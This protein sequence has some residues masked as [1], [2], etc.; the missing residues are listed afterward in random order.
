M[1]CRH[2]AGPQEIERIA[3]DNDILLVADEV[4][5]GI[6]RTGAMFAVEHTKVVPD[7]IA[8]AKGLGSGL[9]IG[10]IVFDA[11]LDFGVQGAH[12][13]TFGGNALA[14]ASTV[15]TLKTIERDGLHKRAAVLGERMHKRLEEMHDQFPLIGDNRGLGL[16]RAS[17]LVKSSGSKEPAVEERD[18]L[19]EEALKRGLILLP[20]GE[21]A[22]RYIP[23]LTIEEDLL[24]TGLDVLEEAFR[25]TSK[26]S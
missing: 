13:N 16:M 4:Q 7:V 1:S 10:A 9:P 11:R 14:C 18:H 5:T 19:I 22:V 3:R 6:G 8:V 12:S 17:E 15:A 25:A 24:E 26:A 20:C 2:Q 23:P 21:S